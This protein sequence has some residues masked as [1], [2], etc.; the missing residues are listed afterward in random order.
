M[1][2]KLYFIPKIKK[3][4]VKINFYLNFNS[5]LP[6]LLAECPPCPSGCW[7][8][9]GA[10]VCKDGQTCF[11]PGT[12]ILMA[13]NS[14]CRIEDIKSGDKVLSYDLEKGLFKPSIVN[15]LIVHQEFFRLLF[16][17]QLS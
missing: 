14:S 13:D 5:D 6:D 17:K 1:K 15:K 4:V 8:D 10:G 12:E 16:N 11:L 2:K 9:T 7:C 3:N